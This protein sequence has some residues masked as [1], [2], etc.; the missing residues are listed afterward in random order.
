MAD[1][2]AVKSSVEPAWATLL[3]EPD[4]EKPYVSRSRMLPML[5]IEN[6]EW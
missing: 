6:P 5:V 1:A 4:A 3:E 2:G